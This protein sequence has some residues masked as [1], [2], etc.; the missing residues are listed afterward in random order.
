M[1][2]TA[3]IRHGPRSVSKKA[4]QVASK[5]DPIF[6]PYFGQILV[7]FSDPFSLVFLAF[8]A[9]VHIRREPIFLKDVPS[10]IVDFKGPGVQET[11]RQGVLKTDKKRNPKNLRTSCFL[12]VRFGVLGRL[13]G[14]SWGTLLPPRRILGQEGRKGKPKS[15]PRT[16]KIG[17]RTA[18]TGP[19]AAQERPNEAH[20]GPRKTPKSLREAQ[21]A[22]NR[23][24]KACQRARKCPQKDPGQA[25]KTSRKQKNKE[26]P[27]HSISEVR[28]GS[29]ELSWKV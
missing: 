21:E 4:S 28:F 3:A 10:E 14:S 17:S 18:K 20:E 2:N 8:F 11:L 29:L 24:P 22:C 16:S 7:Q 26:A 23:G 5:T 27:K 1:R 9:L 19:R 12:G 6:G 25:E 13:L 15:S